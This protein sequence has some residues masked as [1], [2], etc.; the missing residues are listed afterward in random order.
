M[1]LF[2]ARV[3]ATVADL[4]NELLHEITIH[5]DRR[6]LPIFRLV[7]SRWNFLAE[8]D[9]FSHL[10]IHI[11]ADNLDATVQLLQALAQRNTRISKCVRRL[12]VYNVSP[13][14]RRYRGDA[15]EGK[16]AQ[17]A[18]LSVEACIQGAISSL[19]HLESVTWGILGDWKSSP[20][21]AGPYRS[22]LSALSSLEFL[23]SFTLIVD[24]NWSMSDPA[25]PAS[26]L[27]SLSFNSLRRL[28]SISLEVP[29][30][31]L[32]RVQPAVVGLMD[33]N[34][35]ALKSLSLAA[36]ETGYDIF[37]PSRFTSA[38]LNEYI[39]SIMSPLK[40]ES[41][42]LTAWQVT[43]AMGLLESLSTLH[44][45][46]SRNQALWN[47]LRAAKVRIRNLKTD[48]ISQELID[49]I[50]S[51]RGLESLSF[52]NFHHN[53]QPFI[54]NFCNQGLGDH[55]ETLQEL[56][57]VPHHD[58][59]WGFCQGDH[60]VISQCVNLQRLEVTLRCSS[61]D[62]DLNMRLLLRMILSFSSLRQLIVRLP[63]R[64][65]FE[66]REETAELQKCILSFG[67]IPEDTFKVSPTITLGYRV[68]HVAQT[69]TSEWQGLRFKIFRS[70]SS[71]S[72]TPSSETE[73]S[74]ANTR[75]QRHSR[76]ESLRVFDKVRGRING[77]LR[78]S[79]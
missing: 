36:S 61:R 56:C 10:S 8:P 30:P 70:I 47:T 18:R 64:F 4:P 13:T 7:C 44:S 1:R 46:G 69:S 27:N 74:T 24:P 3:R 33:R 34:R 19:I 49:Y 35:N 17:A 63:W 78:L 41:L 55:K 15:S 28:S 43:P 37:G 62:L 23:T 77:L 57:I 72:N 48:R 16:S 25:I 66:D 20:D 21:V 75:S 50:A 2:K 40:L 76:V 6:D 38:Q 68:F 12:H 29:F 9:S 32:Q 54:G 73:R 26:I 67:P 22:I 71:P 11:L 58:I 5:L 60:S 53:Y 14:S 42:Y 51:Y 79:S 39:N 59:N 65:D 52:Y 45:F 31:I